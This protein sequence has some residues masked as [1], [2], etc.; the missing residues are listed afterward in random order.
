MKR[1]F[2]TAIF[3]AVA[4]SCVV[5]SA[6]DADAQ[7]LQLTGPLKGAPAVR[8]MRLYR[9]GRFEAAPTFSASLLDEY[10]R[11]FLIGARLT[12]N[13]TDW[14]GVGVWGGFTFFSPQTD[15]TTQIDSVAPRDPL[16][17]TNVDHGGTYGA[18]TKAP[19]AN[20]TAKLNW[21]LAPQVT[22]IPFRG[23]LAI[24]NKIFVDAD[25]YAAAGI[26][27][28]GISERGSCGDTGQP[29]CAA[30]SSFGLQDSVRSVFSGNQ[31]GTYAFGF[32][33]YPGD[34]WS[35]G[36]EYRMLPLDWNRSG[37]DS[38]G[39]GPNGNFPDQ[40]IN[41][42]DDTFDFNQM[43]TLSVGFSFPTHPKL[44]E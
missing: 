1:R 11:S 44:S 4:A 25:F 18:Y 27:F 32:T 29:S 5:A 3:A 26:A 40:K 22:F 41:S 17:A 35:I 9:Q 8:G 33:F 37:F 39:A 15:L 6:S 24:F 16:T 42:K 14:L 23:K 12:Y 30:S 2:V 13:I 10:R 28:M 34:L 19:F 38:R 36:I 43:I 31:F 20:Q 7:E 21:V